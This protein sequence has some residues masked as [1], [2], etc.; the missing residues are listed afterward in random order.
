MLSM[1]SSLSAWKSRRPFPE[2]SSL[3]GAPMTTRIFGRCRCRHERRTVSVPVSPD[4][5]DG[6]AG[7]YGQKCGPRLGPNQPLGGAA[8]SLGCQAENAAVLQDFQCLTQSLAVRC[9]SVHEDDVDAAQN[10]PAQAALVFAGGECS[11]LV[12]DGQHHRR[13]VHC[14]HVVDGD[15]HRAGVWY[16][17]SPADVIVCQQEEQQAYHGPDAPIPGGWPG[18]AGV[19]MCQ[20]A[21]AEVVMS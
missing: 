16:V 19:V 11:G 3:Y 15:D 1:I 5:Q 13:Q 6:C 9:P 17:L 14:T 18:N 4:G 7:A 12:G 21:T 10:Q 8:G 20:C 2:A